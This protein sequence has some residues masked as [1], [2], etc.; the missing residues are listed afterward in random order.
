M[1]RLIVTFATYRQSSSVSREILAHN[2]DNRL[3]PR[4]PGHRLPAKII[5]DNALSISG[6]L[7]ERPGGPSVKPYQPG[8]LWIE[9]STRD[10]EQDHGADLYR[11]GLYSYWRRSIPPVNMVAFDA[12]SRNT[13]TV[14]R[15]RTNT[16]LMA[17][18]T[19][20]DPTF[21]EAARAMAERIM[22]EAA[23][24]NQK[25]VDFA[26]RLVTARQPTATVRQVLLN[27][28]DEELERYRNDLD[29]VQQLLDGGE[30]PRNDEMNPTDHAAWT[31]VCRLILNLDET[32]TKG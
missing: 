29:G 6:L 22:T 13:C 8:G 19:L 10:Y 5:R 32:I 21:V 7:I 25:R 17:L 26:F 12:P 23:T 30:S 2:P 28:L 31:T 20:N 11:R 3:L 27:V 16:P 24:S 9:Q 15:Q 1:L 18:V 4:G 14:R